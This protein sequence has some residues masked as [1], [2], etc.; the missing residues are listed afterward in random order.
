MMVDYLFMFIA[1]SF[2]VCV[3]LIVWLAKF[4]GGAAQQG[5]FL[6]KDASQLFPD[7]ELFP[8]AEEA[9]G[10]RGAER[11][12]IKRVERFRHGR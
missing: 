3:G 6:P 9:N 2:V 10:Y 5:L 7:S 4:S 8:E 11:R 1:I 12:A